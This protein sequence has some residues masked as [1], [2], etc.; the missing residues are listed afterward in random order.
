TFTNRTEIWGLVWSAIMER[1]WT[2][3]GFGAFWVGESDWGNAI[4]AKLGW[5][6]TIS[7]AHNAW[8]ETWLSIGVV[9]LAVAIS[10]LL[11]ISVK[12]LRRASA[13]KQA[14]TDAW[15]V[16]SVGFILTVWVYSLTESIF[17]S[18]NTLTWV[19]FIVLAVRQSALD[20][21]GSN[22]VD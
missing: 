18:Y 11:A 10:L 6:E 3:Y 21:V 2:G 12:V 22:R 8:L 4:R 7:E 16:W 17:P 5:G 1:P 14:A 13:R 9:G 19:L 20:N 15:T